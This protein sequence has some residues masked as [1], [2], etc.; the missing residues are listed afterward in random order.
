MNVVDRHRVKECLIGTSDLS[1]HNMI[2]L[3]VQFLSFA[4]S[5]T[6]RLNLGILNKESTIKEIKGEITSCVGDNYNCQ[7]KPIV[8]WDTV[9]AVMRGRLTSRAAHLKK[10]AYDGAAY[11]DLE[12]DL[13]NFKLQQK[14]KDQ[15]LVNKI[16]ATKN[17]IKILVQEELEKRLRFCKQSLYE[18]GPKATKF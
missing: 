14:G 6:W 5:A 8:M 15:S 3:S 10:A 13:R 18:S 17:K 9:K 12:K 7:V 2:Y 11:D 16:R 1:D 4:K